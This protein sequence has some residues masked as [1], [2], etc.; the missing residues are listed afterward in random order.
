MEPWLDPSRPPPP[1]RLSCHPQHSM[2]C[3]A[4]WRGI[5]NGLPTIEL[6][7]RPRKS[8]P[9]PQS[10]CCSL[11]APDPPSAP[12]L[13]QLRC[14]RQPV[15]SHVCLPLS[16]LALDYGIKFMETSAKANI[17]VENVS[18]G[19][20][21]ETWG[22]QDWPLQAEGG[23]GVLR[24]GPARGTSLRLRAASQSSEGHFLGNATCQAQAA[25]GNVVPSAR[26]GPTQGT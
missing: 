1:S 25:H 23:A 15:S 2:P 12:V 7:E 4:L 3:V 22:L 26:A 24:G 14:A 21:W 11:L 20:C 10:R 16:Q 5:H 13:G 18:P 17:N 8:L 9:Q 19:P 6:R